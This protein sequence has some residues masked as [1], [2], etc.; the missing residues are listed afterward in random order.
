M[1][2]QALKTRSLL[3]VFMLLLSTNSVEERAKS[4]LETKLLRKLNNKSVSTA[5]IPAET[6]E[7][8]EIEL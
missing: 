2:M 1:E 4:E 7:Q 3:L 5:Q 8:I 6:K